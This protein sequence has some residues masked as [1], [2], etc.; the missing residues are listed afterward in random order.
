[1]GIKTDLSEGVT[2][3]TS[4]NEKE[5]ATT[6]EAAAGGIGERIGEKT[7]GTAQAGTGRRLGRKEREHIS[8]LGICR[9]PDGWADHRSQS[10]H[11]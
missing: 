2:M 8:L 7:K 10:R 5:E 3:E 6:E 4:G 11:R 1:M 9:Y